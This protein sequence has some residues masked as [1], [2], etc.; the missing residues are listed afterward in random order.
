MAC[1]LSTVNICNFI[2]KASKPFCLP[3][4]KSTVFEM[5]QKIALYDI[6]W[7]ETKTCIIKPC[8]HETGK[9]AKALLKRL[10][11]Q[12]KNMLTRLINISEKCRKKTRQMCERKSCGVVHWNFTFCYRSCHKATAEILSAFLFRAL[13]INITCEQRQQRQQQRKKKKN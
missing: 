8:K 4:N 13:Q 2:Y 3:S 12:Q 10:K 9:M 5:T 11:E 6:L 7:N 1:N